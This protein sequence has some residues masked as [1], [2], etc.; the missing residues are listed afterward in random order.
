MWVTSSAV[1]MNL[2]DTP[3]PSATATVT[4]TV[5]EGATV[6]VEGQALKTQTGTTRQFV[7]PPLTPG[8]AYT[9]D[10]RATWTGPDG[11]KVERTVSVDIR[12]GARE[13][14]A[15]IVYICYSRHLCKSP[16]RTSPLPRSN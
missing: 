12:A 8:K 6:Y 7:S 15:F 4:V 16:R 9:Y 10:I 5:P 3:A 13:S 14:V 11:K 1:S 2:K